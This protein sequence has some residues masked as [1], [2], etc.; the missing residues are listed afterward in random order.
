VLNNGLILAHGGSGELSV[1]GGVDYDVTA[2]HIEFHT[3]GAHLWALL[4]FVVLMRV[5]VG[6]VGVS[7]VVVLLGVVMRLIIVVVTEV[8]LFLSALNNKIIVRVVVFR[9]QAAALLIANKLDLGNVDGIE[10]SDD[11]FA[12]NL[13]HSLGW[14]DSSGG[15][16]R[17]D[18][19][20]DL[21]VTANADKL[22]SVSASGALMAV[23]GVNH[24]ERLSELFLMEL[25]EAHLTFEK[26]LV[27]ESGL[28]T[29]EQL[30]AIGHHVE[31]E[32]ELLAV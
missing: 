11:C 21:D 8:L 25:L 13:N 26:V 20:V 22:N 5:F 32:S 30:F 18:R 7:V 19:R 3:V 4:V 28:S 15:K 24:R 16:R 14:A 23:V 6:K 27:I 2:N 31:I 29:V 9:D 10:P 12:I 17:V 1:D